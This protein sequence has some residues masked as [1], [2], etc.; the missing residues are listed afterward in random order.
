MEQ[1]L[2]II[3][4]L[5]VVLGGM[6][7]LAAVAFLSLFGGIAGI[8]GSTA[9]PND[10]AVAVPLIS[11][12]GG[13]LF[14]VCLVFSLPS[15]VGGIALL[16]MASWSRIFMLVVSGLYLLHLPIGTALGIY[17]IWAL[18]K[19]ETQAIFARRQFLPVA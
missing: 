8:V 6:G 7:V 15:L 5:H 19:P 13:V 2:K 16:K 3:G 1:H 11:G 10:A 12:F 9:Q 14:I 4:I 17:G 18:T